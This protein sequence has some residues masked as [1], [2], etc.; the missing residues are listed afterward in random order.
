MTLQRFPYATAWVTLK[1]AQMQRA[2]ART[3][4]VVDGRDLDPPRCNVQID[5]SL[6]LKS[7]GSI[8]TLDI[9]T[10]G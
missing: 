7:H 8:Q 5:M 3:S 4:T 2:L 9:L 1:V 6:S 10:H